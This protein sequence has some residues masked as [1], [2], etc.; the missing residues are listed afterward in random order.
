MRLANLFFASLLLAPTAI[1]QNTFEIWPGVTNFTSRGSIGNN[2]AGGELLQGIAA[3]AFTGIGDNGAVARVDGF[4]MILQDQNTDTQED[5][6]LV[7]RSGDDTA[8]P[9][10]TNTGLLCRMGPFTSPPR[11]TGGPIQ[12]FTVT[13]TFGTAA[14]LDLC[15]F[16]AFGVQLEQAAGTGWTSDGLSCH[17]SRG[18]GAF[19]QSVQS[20]ASTA[21]D[22]GWQIIDDVVTHPSLKRSWRFGL[23][24]STALLQLGNGGTSYGQGGAD[25]DVGVPYSGRVRYGSTSS[26]DNSWMFIS[27]S[28]ICPGVSFQPGMRIYLGS[29]HGPFATT[30]PPSGEAVHDLG[31]TPPTVFGANLHF[32]CVGFVQ[33]S[34]HCI[35][36]NLCSSRL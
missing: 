1:A 35:L 22:Q 4:S 19:A 9:N 6:Y 11:G 20:A 18:D 31:M 26:V 15:N 29:I 21:Q 24:T 3:A 12:A 10:G 8:G 13:Q 30:V 32:Q 33:A 14:C 16:S 25:P 2:P 34:G 28:R 7:Y 23:I 36:T 27:G 5:Y 17:I